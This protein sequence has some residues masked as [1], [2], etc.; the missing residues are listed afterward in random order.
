MGPEKVQIWV[1]LPNKEGAAIHN[2]PWGEF[3]K[4]T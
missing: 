1:Q 3:K 2:V 4:V